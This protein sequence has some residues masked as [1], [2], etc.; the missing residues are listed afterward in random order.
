[1]VLLDH[2]P[3]LGSCE[4]ASEPRHRQH[5][6]QTMFLALEP[7]NLNTRRCFRRIPVI[8]C[9]DGVRIDTLPVLSLLG[10]PE[11]CNTRGECPQSA[12][13]RFIKA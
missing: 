5:F 1:M 6:Q 8:I 2:L 7:F 4:L 9:T 12:R 3:Y 11:G 10:L 13:G